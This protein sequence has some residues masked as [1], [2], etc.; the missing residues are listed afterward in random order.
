MRQRYF[1]TGETF[2]FKFSKSSMLTKYEWV[3][4]DQ[5]DDEEAEEAGG[6][7]RDRAKEL[8]MS[9]DN[10][11]V[12]VGGGWDDRNK[13]IW[14]WHLL[15]SHCRGGTAIYLDENI[16]FGQTEKCD[17]FENTPLCSSRDFS[18]NAIE[19]FGFVDISWWS[20]MKGFK[21]CSCIVRH[22]ILNSSHR[23]ENEYL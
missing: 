7:R 13:I 9:A 18:I 15:I 21:M 16:R 5:S 1:G 12:T 8:F 20:Q 17:T 19:V 10:T 3:N 23:E 2:L 14:S 22:I 11:M 6:R 4:K